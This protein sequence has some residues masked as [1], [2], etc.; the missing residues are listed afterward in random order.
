MTDGS[1][2]E[3]AGR[4]AALIVDYFTDYQKAWILDESQMKLAEKSRRIGWT[5]ATSFRR[6]LKAM[7]VPELDC[8]VSTRDLSTAKEF[9][10]DCVRWVRLAN[11]VGQVSIGTEVIDIEKNVSAQ[12]IA[13]P[14]GSRIYVLT[15]NPDALAGKGGDIVLDEFALHKDQQLLWQV[16]LPTAS[17][18]GYQIEVI[19]THRGKATLF[20][21]FVHDAKKDNRMGWSFYSVNIVQACEQGLI[22][23]INAAVAKRG[24]APVEAA[25]FVRKQRA[26]CATEG[27]WNQEFMCQPQD[28]LGSLLTYAMIAGCALPWDTLRTPPEPV[29]GN[30]YA[31]MDIARKRNLS[32]IWIIEDFGGICWT[33]R[34]A[35]MAD[36]K[37]RH[38]RETFCTLYRN[39]QCSGGGID[40][41]GM[42]TQLA[43]DAIDELG[44]SAL[45]AVVFTAQVQNEMANIMLQEFEDKTVRVP[46]E[47]TIEES[48]HKVQKA[49][50]AK[51]N[52]TYVAADDEHGHA[53]EFWALALAL[54]ASRRGGGVTAG[55]AIQEA[56][57]LDDLTR[58]ES[59]RTGRHDDA[60]ASHH[61]GAEPAR[62]G[63]GRTW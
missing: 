3:G 51:G 31:G 39:W 18:W 58:I 22:A 49:V 6:V 36:T 29:L 2:R 14:N 60:P 52:I 61:P 62:T 15:S 38:Q 23:R 27:Q 30:R 40:A 9:V 10:R 41:T 21:K 17:V 55:L 42:G 19:S 59:K 8:W 44:T 63:I 28:D 56:D 37:L 7:R 16:A 35:T 1:K 24:G 53:D 34:I 5:Y 46:D 43:E 45:E 12:V 57:P 4:L 20:N 25:D 47:R 48:L 32:V 11:L 50:T 54:R 33:R 13:F 26:R